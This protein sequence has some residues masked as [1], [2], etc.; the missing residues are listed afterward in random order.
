MEMFGGECLKSQSHYLYTGMI[1][2]EKENSRQIQ[3]A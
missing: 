2:I 1:L 3:F